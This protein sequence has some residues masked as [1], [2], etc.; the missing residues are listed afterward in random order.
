MWQTETGGPVFGNPYGIG[1]AADQAR[2]GRHPAARDRRRG[3]HRR[4]PAAARPARRAS[5]SITPAVPRPDRQPLGRAG[6][7]R[8]RLLG[9]DPGRATTTGDAAHIDEDGY[10]WFAGRADEIIKIAAHRHRHD[11]GRDGASCA[12]R[13]S[14]RPAS[15]GVPDE[16]RGEVIAAFV[17]LQAGPDAVGR[18]AP[19]AARHASGSE[20]GAGRGHRRA[21]VRRPCCRRRAAARSC[22]GSSRPSPLDRDPGDITTI[23]DEGSVEEAR[24]AVDELHA[25]IR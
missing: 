18:A 8:P 4:G 2:L 20:L 19:R 22:A 11:R 25:D 6:A 3:R 21:L 7:L 15:P 9:A 13:P 12:T 23:E 1:A 24:R 5:W 14:P 16:L 17:V 10:V